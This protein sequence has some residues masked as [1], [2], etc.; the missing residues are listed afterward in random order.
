MVV[1]FSEIEIEKLLEVQMIYRN[2]CYFVF[3]RMQYK[4]M[5][6]KYYKK[7]DEILMCESQNLTLLTV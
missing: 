6:E 5:L 4:T 1:V 3:L 7:Y 2:K